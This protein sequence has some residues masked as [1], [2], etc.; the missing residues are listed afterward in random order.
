M[1]KI[2]SDLQ[3]YARPLAPTLVETEFGFHVLQVTDSRPAG[4]VPLEEI[5]DGI[6]SQIEQREA[7]LKDL[8]KQLQKFEEARKIFESP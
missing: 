8:R 5:R 7:E 4:T 3:D 1:N 2:V 6:R